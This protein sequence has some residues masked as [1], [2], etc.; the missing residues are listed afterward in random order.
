[1]HNVRP[2]KLFNL[3]K[4]SSYLD[5]T[6][7][8]ILPDQRTPVLLDT[9]ILLALARL[10]RARTI[11][12]FG[13][14][15]GIQTLNL[16]AN[17]PEGRIY[18]LDLDEASFQGLQ[19]DANDKPLTQTHME[20]QGKLAFLNTPYE[21]RITRLYG[22]SN[23]F[24]FLGLTSRIDLIYVDGGHDRITLESDTKNAFKMLSHGHA[25]CIAWHDHG[26]PTY[27]QVKEYLEGLSNSKDLFHVEESWTTFFLQNSE[28]LVTQLKN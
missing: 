14:Y 15:L 1:L 3:V 7:Q 9:A 11:F 5:R 10:V 24:D 2:H 4:S 18:T 28:D 19:Q 21:E 12:E 25:G 17:F 6:V 27:P 13:T 23:K 22:D 16:A 20:Y 8:M 26:N